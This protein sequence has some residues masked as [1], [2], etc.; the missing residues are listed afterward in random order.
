MR[1]SLAAACFLLL[2]AAAAHA[3]SGQLQKTSLPIDGNG[4]GSFE[5]D[6]TVQY[7]LTFT[8]TGATDLTNVVILDG[9]SG[10]ISLDAG[11]VVVEPASGGTVSGSI[12]VDLA[13]PLP[14]GE[15]VTITFVGSATAEGPCCNQAT[16]TSTEVP[17][18]VSDLDP[19]DATRDEP[20]CHA[21]ATG[22][23][24]ETDAIVDKQVLSAGCLAPGSTVDFRIRVQNNG[25]RPLRNV[26]I[27]DQLD[28]GFT[29]VVV[30]GGLSYDPA[31]HRVFMDGGTW[32]V[33]QETFYTYSA[34][35]PCS[36]TGSLSN[37][38]VVAF[39][40]N[41]GTV[42]TRS[43]T[44]SVTWG[45]ADLS[46]STKRWREDP[47]DADNVVSPGENVTFT[48]T[49]N[50]TG[51]CEALNVSAS[52]A[53]DARFVERAPALV[54]GEG[55]AWNPA[56][57]RIEWTPA[58]TPEL[59]AI[60]ALGSVTLTFTTQVEPGTPPGVIPNSVT[61]DVV[62]NDSTCP[63]TPTY[64]WSI[65]LLNGG[66]VQEGVV[67]TDTLLRNDFVSCLRDAAQTLRGD[68][69]VA[70][71][72]P[73]LRQR[74]PPQTCSSPPAINPSHSQTDAIVNPTSP[75]VFTG[76]ATSGGARCPQLASGNGRT[77]V[78]YEL[79]DNCTST[80]RV[81]KDP[82]GRDVVVTW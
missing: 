63:G 1:A 22:P 2:A 21:V 81:R 65:A 82:S 42:F 40:D 46:A 9:S 20:T 58:G 79:D 34:T 54:V 74:R 41:R 45:R 38:V 6:E 68:F 25:R 36:D 19:A 56:S 70:G 4:N 52:D 39:E 73:V 44:E 67:V 69:P 23:G 55:G 3:Q 29:D 50:N 33:G 18:G 24:P 27:E 78:F 60:P 76:D 28:P 61:L 10:C 53:L 16:W 7:T 49:V 26:A 8:N 77:L 30:G 48:I 12:Q 35:L 59:A 11:S 43:D 47:S 14:P 17:S 62:G 15:T 72:L 32:G 66:V 31:A 71:M 13:S 75:Y 80:L 37:T 64:T 51:A 5:V 57:G